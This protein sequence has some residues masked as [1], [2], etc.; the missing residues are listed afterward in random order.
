MKILFVSQYFYPETFRGNDIVF[1]FIK[2]GHEVTVITGKPNYPLGSFY[3][4]YKFWGVKKE[5]I[6]GAD[7]IRIP[8]FPRGKGSGLKLIL[9]YA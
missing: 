5:I 1:D 6:N 7:V 4:G 8:T 2:K 9:N 3:Q